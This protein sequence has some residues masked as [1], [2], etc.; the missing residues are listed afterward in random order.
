MRWRYLRWVLRA[1]TAAL[2]SAGAGVL[3]LAS[4][5]PLDLN[6]PDLAGPTTRRSIGNGLS[7]PDRADLE[8]LCSRN[9]RRPLI[10]PV[11]LPPPPPP[12]PAPLAI[13]LAG[14]IV[15]EGH[16]RAM[17]VGTDGRMQLKRVG[18]RCGEAQIL[19]IEAGGITVLHQGRTVELRVQKP[20]SP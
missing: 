16:S 10:D 12:P 9:L 2:L 4:R 7:L 5:L 13:Q 6:E 11:P 19:S 15:E 18:D 20:K 3:F 14:T 1:A 8:R 17:V